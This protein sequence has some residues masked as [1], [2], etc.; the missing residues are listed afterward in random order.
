MGDVKDYSHRPAEEAGLANVFSPKRIRTGVKVS[1][2]KRLLE[3]LSNLLTEGHDYDVDKQTVFKALVERERLGSTCVGNGVVLPHGRLN[4]L[5]QAC[6][7]IIRV[8]SPLDLDAFDD[9]PV[10]LACGLLVPAECAEV[11]VQILRKLAVGFEKYDLHH[12][13]LMAENANKLFLELI[14]FDLENSNI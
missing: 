9:K 7:A 8:E 2:Q 6:G 3:V 14:S 1:S 12:S 11:H 10:Q 4:S 13:L 5:P